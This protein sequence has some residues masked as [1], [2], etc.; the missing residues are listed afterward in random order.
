MLTVYCLNQSCAQP[1]YYSLQKP[2]LCGFCGSRLDGLAVATKKIPKKVVVEDVEDE[3]VIED[4]SPKSLK[5]R[6]IERFKN[7]RAAARETEEEEVQIPDIDKLEYEI[8]GS[9]QKLTL[10]N[11]GSQAKAGFAPRP[12]ESISQEESIRLFREEAK[13]K[14]SPIE[15]GDEE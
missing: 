15:L 9:R 4:H 10:E 6:N 14:S 13:G 12:V 11:L 2:V 5:Q 8:V 3:E 1:N 7:R